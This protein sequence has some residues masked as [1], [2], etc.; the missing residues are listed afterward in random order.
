MRFMRDKM[1]EISRE[2]RFKLKSAY[3][4]WVHDILN[5]VWNDQL[6]NGFQV[7]FM[8]NHIPGNFE[9]KCEVMEDEIDR[10]YRTL[11]PHVERSPRSPAG[12]KRLP[13]L[14]AFPD[15]PT[16]KLNRSSFLDMKINDGLHYHGVVLVHTES[17]LKIGL[18]I[19]MKDHADRYIRHGGA[20]RRIQIQ[21]IDQPSARTAV[22][23][24][25]KALGWRIPDTDRI[26]I[27]PRAVTELPVGKSHHDE[28][29]RRKAQ[30]PAG[31][32]RDNRIIVVPRTP[33][34]HRF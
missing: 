7:T 21:P 13:I 6:W 34:I 19:H 5:N 1:Y 12:S 4:N 17:R 2:R 30:E 22:G 24:G 27:R 23:Y 28:R 14:L 32:G 31:R 26:F 16:R 20:L 3:S 15:Y 10:V 11:V 33:P 9:R 25:F 29:K 18:D 8:F